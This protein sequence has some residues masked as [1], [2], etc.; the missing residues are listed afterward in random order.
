MCKQWRFLCESQF[1]LA[2][3][4][5][6]GI[7]LERPIHGLGLAVGGM[8]TDVS[9]SN[10]HHRTGTTAISWP[11]SFSRTQRSDSRSQTTSPTDLLS[12]VQVEQF[13]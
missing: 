12:E 7:K 10:S 4:N 9:V 11:F 2:S 8:N 13:T 3:S 5:S 1:Y 6:A